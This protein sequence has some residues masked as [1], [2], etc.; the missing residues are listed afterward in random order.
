MKRHDEHSY[1][2]SK[3]VHQTFEKGSVVTLT[4]DLDGDGTL[5]ASVNGQ[6]FALFAGMRKYTALGKNNSFL[7]YVHQNQPGRIR[8]L[9]FQSMPEYESDDGDEDGSTRGMEH[10]ET[11]T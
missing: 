2:Y 1:N 5:F 3:K 6:E 9:G 8:F 7:P 4:I 10:L 11:I